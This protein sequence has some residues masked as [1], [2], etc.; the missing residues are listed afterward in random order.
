[1]LQERVPPLIVMYNTL[2]GFI[3]KGGDLE[4]VVE[5]KRAMEW[6]G[7]LTRPNTCTREDYSATEK[8]MFDM[9]YQE[10]KPDR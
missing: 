2:I 6:S 9:K 8:M 5:V 7:A 1:M 4:R 3:C 10:C